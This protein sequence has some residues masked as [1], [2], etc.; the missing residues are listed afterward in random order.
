MF[1]LFKQPEKKPKNKGTTS[2]PVTLAGSQNVAQVFDQ[3]HLDKETENLIA[4]CYFDKRPK[5]YPQVYRRIYDLSRNSKVAFH[6]VSW[7]IAISFVQSLVPMFLSAAGLPL[8]HPL[9][10]WIIGGLLLGFFEYGQ[11]QTL[12]TLWT[13]Y[14]QTKKVVFGIA[15]LTLLFSTISVVT[16]V[17]AAFALLENSTYQLG[18]V[19]LA[20]FVEFMILTNSYNIHNYRQKTANTVKMLNEFGNGIDTGM[21]FHNLPKKSAATALP[22]NYNQTAPTAAKIEIDQGAKKIVKPSP[23]EI[24]TF[25]LFK[26]QSNPIQ[27]IKKE[28]KTT[29]TDSKNNQKSTG[30]VATKTPKTSVPTDFQ[31]IE[32]KFWTLKN[33]ESFESAY[34]NKIDNEGNNFTRIANWTFFKH[35]RKNW[36]K[37]SDGKT[38]PQVGAPERKKWY[39]KNHP[40]VSAKLKLV[41]QKKKGK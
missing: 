9:Q 4:E 6:V 36:K 12:E 40:A 2:R 19:A 8:L 13:V 37:F 10:S 17:Y 30:N 25:S 26:Q 35:Y 7:C 18:L 11:H 41:D 34:K 32:G 3:Y 16:S 33:I 38:A 14:F 21:Y 28:K 39:E 20:L 15:F 5:T 27:G 22:P 1:D 23:L 31:V 24:K 29:E